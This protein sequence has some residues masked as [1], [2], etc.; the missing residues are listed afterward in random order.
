MLPAEIAPGRVPGDS[1]ST[2]VPA[3]SLPGSTPMT[4]RN[5][6]REVVSVERY[7]TLAEAARVRL[8]T[9]GYDNVDV[10]VGDGLAG[11]PDRAPYDRIIVTV[12]AW[13]IPPAWLDQLRPGG[14]IVV[15]LRFAAITRLIAFDRAVVGPALVASNYRLGSFVPVQGDGAATEKLIAVTPD[16]GLRIDQNSMLAFDVPAQQLLGFAAPV[17]SLITGREGERDR[18]VV[19]TATPRFGIVGQRQTVGYRVEDEGAPRGA[20]VAVVVRTHPTAG[21]RPVP[22]PAAGRNCAG[23]AADCRCPAAAAT[24]RCESRNTCGSRSRRRC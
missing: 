16:I 11:M 4:R 14:R 24:G 12:G 9:L 22:K 13:D 2:G 17:H 23:C 1:R 6:A 10:L 20:R 7:R 3:V 8:R 5:T 19:L 15:P 21:P 18:R